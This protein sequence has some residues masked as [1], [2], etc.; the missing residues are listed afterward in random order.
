MC[1]R[2]RALAVNGLAQRVDDT[3]QETITHRDAGALAAAGHQSAHAY[4]L[5]TVEQNNACLLYT[6]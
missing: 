1:I 5:G 3:A 6:S 2:D 4:G